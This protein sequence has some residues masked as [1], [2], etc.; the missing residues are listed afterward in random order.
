[1]KRAHVVLLSL[2]LSL[3][4]T[5]AHAQDQQPS[6]PPA[7]PPTE[8][9]SNPAAQPAPLGPTNAAATTKK[10]GPLANAV[11]ARTPEEQ[12]RQSGFQFITALDHYLGVGTFIDAKYYSSLS[13]WLTIIPQF[14]IHAG[15]QLLVVSATVRGSYE[16]TLP[17]VDT[18]RHWAIFD[19]PVGLSAP[20][21]FRDPLLGIAFS[22][23]VSLTIP[24]S[25][26]SW[27]AGLI[28]TIRGGLTMSRSIKTVDLRAVVSG[29]GSIFGQSSSGLRNPNANGA[30]SRDTQGNLLSICRPGETLCAIAGNNTAFLFQAG[31]QVQWR[32]SGSII[33]YA[34]YF[35][36]KSWRYA[37]N[38][39]ADPYTP[40][41]TDANG[42]PVARVGLGQFDRTST[43]VGG[44]YQLNEHYSLDLGVQTTQTPLTATGQ[45]RFPFLSFGS[46]S[47]NATSIYFS[48]TAAY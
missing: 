8:G 43:S 33:F 9:N 11:Q 29:S 15:K 39:E 35:F 36:I 7:T 25:L 30:I 16:Y 42:N 6:S 4:A 10:A 34:S 26:E 41:G 24:T 3:V 12:A 18:G 20:A 37:V 1:M 27:N 28:T 14:L 32:A 47:D 21:L 40:Q 13:A 2:L 45:V 22:P 38:T 17:D 31:G 23:S 19:T 46:W 48:L 44:S 5:S